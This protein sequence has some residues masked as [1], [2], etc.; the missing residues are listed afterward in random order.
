MALS[1]TNEAC[2][3][4]SNISKSYGASI[5]LKE[6]NLSI[7]EGEF[8]TILG[9]SGSGKTTILRLIGGFTVPDNGRVLFRGTDITR[10]PIHRPPV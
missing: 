10:T 8:L 6:I 5:V 7:E 3:R 4:L 2:L 1:E 9:P